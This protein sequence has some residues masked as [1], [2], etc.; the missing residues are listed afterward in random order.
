MKVVHRGA[1]PSPSLPCSVP[2]LH[3][4]TSPLLQ[5]APPPQHMQ[6]MS[7][8]LLIYFCGPSYSLRKSPRVVQHMLHTRITYITH[9][10]P[11]QQVILLH[12]ASLQQHHNNVHEKKQEMMLLPSIRSTLRRHIL[13]TSEAKI[14]LGIMQQ[15]RSYCTKDATTSDEYYYLGFLWEKLLYYHAAFLQ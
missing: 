1:C 15:P 12:M 8:K 5:P 4:Y 2:P 11:I 6:L 9:H 10:F 14:W 13:S 7:L 3:C